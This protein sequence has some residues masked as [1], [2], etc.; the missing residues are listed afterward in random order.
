MGFSYENLVIGPVV[1]FGE[2]ATGGHFLESLK[3]AKQAHASSSYRQIVGDM[4]RQHGLV[5]TFY[6]G[7]LPW[8]A[9]QSVKGLPLLFVKE[10]ISR[11]SRSKGGDKKTADLL[12]GI[13][14]GMSQS[15]FITPTQRMKTVA[16][17]N[18]GE[19]PLAS[20]RAAVALEGPA[21][22]FRGMG[23]MVAKR[24]T[25][26]GIRFYA[27]SWATEY[28]MDRPGS[29]LWRRGQHPDPADRHGRGRLSEAWAK[30][31]WLPG[32]GAPRAAASRL[33]ALLPRMGDE[34]RPHFLPH[35]LGGRPGNR[36][37]PVLSKPQ[38]RVGYLD[39]ARKGSEEFRVAVTLRLCCGYVKET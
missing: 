30:R 26:W 15:V 12:G 28:L 25:D 9:L 18:R 8:G 36:Y 17:T 7:F 29:Q 32:G 21:T 38:S 6:R 14:G 23:P 10:E 3:I 22:P 39:C 31:R 24:G 33:E 13:A 1:V 34:S 35:R 37:L 19:A 4:Y 2:M 11:Y 20:I 16:L 27:M 5:R